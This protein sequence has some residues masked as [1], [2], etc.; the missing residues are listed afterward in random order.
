MQSKR[1][2][3]TLLLLTFIFPVNLT[4]SMPIKEE[5][6]VG[7]KFKQTRLTN[8]YPATEL[9]VVHTDLYLAQYKL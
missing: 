3:R 8:W 9:G 1:L 2:S 4:Y 7:W 6:N 5:L